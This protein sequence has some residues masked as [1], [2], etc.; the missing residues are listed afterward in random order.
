MQ[1]PALSLKSLA[2]ADALGSSG[3]TPGVSPPMGRTLRV[4]SRMP[5][6]KSCDIGADLLAL[7]PL[8]A[9]LVKHYGI[10]VVAT[11]QSISVEDEVAE[12]I[13]RRLVVN[14]AA[15]GVDGAV[16]VVAHVFGHMVQFATTDRFHSMLQV[17]ER[18]APPFDFDEEFKRRYWAYEEE[19]CAIGRGLLELVFSVDSN[20]DK[21]YQVFTRTDLV[22]YWNY[23][24][25]G[26]RTSN[27]EF[28]R[29]FRQNYLDMHAKLVSPLRMIAP[30]SFL[31]H[32]AIRLLAVL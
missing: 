25:T 20:V 17:I 4:E 30:P 11:D 26:R 19:A 18:G 12:L 22:C 31:S 27:E 23:L 10:E 16:F 13:M 21:H 15:R 1:G 14:T 29:L 8:V 3:L 2:T 5:S 32:Q 24:S 28:E 9:Y 6:Q 7:E